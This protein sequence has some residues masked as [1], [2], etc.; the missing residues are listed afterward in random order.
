MAAVCC[1]LF[2]H[3]SLFVILCAFAASAM[4]AAQA[5]PER[6]RA[7]HR[8]FFMAVLTV[9]PTTSGLHDHPPMWS[10]WTSSP[11][12]QQFEGAPPRVHCDHTWGTL[13]GQL[14]VVIWGHCVPSQLLYQHPFYKDTIVILGITIHQQPHQSPTRL[15]I[16]FVCDHHC[17]T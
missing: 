12:T 14:L 15:V 6:P 10:Q 16:I 9:S 13:S 1:D 5:S 4:L 3:L 7:A 11:V 2:W 8:V 17:A